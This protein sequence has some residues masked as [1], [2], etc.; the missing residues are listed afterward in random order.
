M[1]AVTE[2][3]ST[4]FDQWAHVYDDQPNPLLALEERLLPKLLPNLAGLDILDVGCGTGRWL[5]RFEAH[6]PASLT[7]CDSSPVMLDFARRKLSPHTRLHLANSTS[8]PACDAAYDIILVSFVLGYMEDLP[9]FIAECSRI[10]KPGGHLFVS[11]PHPHTATRLGWKRSF[12]VGGNSV[13]LPA[14]NY[15]IA[16]LLKAFDQEHFELCNLEEPSFDTPEK[17]I[18]EQSSRLPEYD[19]LSGVPAIY[20]LKLKKRTADHNHPCE[21]P[22]CLNTVFSQGPEQWS[23]TPITIVS[24]NFSNRRSSPAAPLDLSGFVLLPGLINAHDH[25]EFALFPNLGRDSEAAPYQNASEWADEI[26]QNHTDMIERH[27][28]VPLETRLWWGAIRNLLC[29]VTTVC[30]HNPL[31]PE[32]LKSDFPVRVLNKFGW[33]HSL[34]FA[35]DPVAA[36]KEMPAGHPFILHA[37]EGTDEQSHNELDEIDR[38]QLLNQQTVV[39]HGLSLTATQIQRL[40]V[41]GAALILCPTSNQ[42]LFHQTLASPLIQSVDR[43]AIG[44]DSPITATG[45]LLD[46]VNFLAKTQC[47]SSLALYNAVTTI[48][49]NILRLSNG[50]GEIRP[51]APADFIAVR[52]RHCSPSETLVGLTFAGIELVVLGGRIQLAS[53]TVYSRLTDAQRNDLHALQVSGHRRWLRAPL[54]RLFASAEQVL[55]RGA[56]RLGNKEVRCCSTR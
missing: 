31:Y 30:H 49:A 48:P 11:D 7:G 38:L 45:D 12:T 55:G 34:A 32:L 13:H 6:S 10:L 39:V 18:F 8:L 23:S 1:D 20:L 36:Y 15:L 35:A 41:R 19:K 43:C 47:L 17:I 51:G 24:G 44:S 16:D 56:L 27:M 29:G 46:E 2:S 54:P 53:D 4:L 26:H 9:A 42:F 22:S 50:Q 14:K 40:N 5:K 21:M 28:S 25:L 52:E 33:A 3:P 37:A